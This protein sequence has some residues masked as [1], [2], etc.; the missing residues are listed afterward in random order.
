MR[1]GIV[2]A[3]SPRLVKLFFLAVLLS[4]QSGLLK[5]VI[6]VRSSVVRPHT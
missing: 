5:R 2:L 6:F 4:G 3:W 1:R